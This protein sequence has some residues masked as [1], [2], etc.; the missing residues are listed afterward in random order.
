MSNI[1]YSVKIP[2]NVDLSGDRTLQRALES[3]Q[4]NFIKWWDDVGP[5]GSTNHDVYLRTAVSVDPQGWAQFGYVKMRDYRW[6]IF[7]NPAD[8]DRA[9]H[10]GDHKGEKA[11]QEVPGEHR[12]NLR[13]I[14]VTQGDT[15]PASVE[16]QRHLGLTAPSLYD[17][18][19]LFQVNV[20]EGRHLWAMVYLLHKYFGRDGREEA[21]ALLER[22]S[23]DENNPRILGAF[24]EKTPDW[25]AFFMFTYFTDR[26]G[27]FQLAALAESAFDPLARTTKF[28]L[29]EEAHH[30]FVGESGVSRVLQRT[31][32]VMNELK[33]DDA[34]KLRAAGVIDLPTMQRYLNFHY[35]VTIDLFGADQSSNAATFYSSGLKGRY[36]EGKRADD[37]ALHD[38]Q[39]KVLEVVDGKLQE[40]DVPMLNA[41][42][43]VLRDDYIK[44]SNAGVGRWNKV[45][46]KAGIDF[47]LTVPHKAFNR[48]IGALAGVRISPDGR[49][50]TEAEWQS[51]KN[52]WLASDDDRTFVASLMKQCLEPGKFAGWIAPP[53]MGINRQPVDFEYVRF[54]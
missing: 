40:K 53:V 29:T 42:N 16:Q 33:T 8:Q 32:Q 38:Q 39:Y 11:W 14:I 37:H 17:L 9:I 54:N 48:Q 31:C 6:G 10:F 27:K 21:E 45:M 7:L 30:M 35:S 20:E 5:E 41:L 43:E 18:R 1:D 34:N 22:Q 52:D 12:A 28:M 13:R 2:N 46:E 26:D 36:E 50:V 4:P 25:L 15:E 44:D 23:G 24:N 51:R 47:R 3:W 49:P 19:N